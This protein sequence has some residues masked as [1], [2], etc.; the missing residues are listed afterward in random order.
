MG[1]LYQRFRIWNRARRYRWKDEPFECRFA[2]DCLQPGD[3]ALDIGAHKAAFT[4]WM[5]RRVGRR[6]R[7]YAFEPQPGLAAYLREFADTTPRRNVVVCEAALADTA[8]RS[9]LWIPATHL[10]WA[11]LQTHL[12]PALDGRLVEV[13]VETLDEWAAENDVPRPVSFIKCDV[14]L[15]ELAVFRGGEQL[16]SRDRPV[17]LFESHPLT[18]VQ[19]AENQTFAFLEQ[20]GYEGFFFHGRELLPVTSYSAACHRLT[21]DQVQNFV[22]VHPAVASLTRNRP[23]YSVQWAR[24][25]GSCPL[26]AEPAAA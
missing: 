7:V 26:I 17:L 18:R 22:F 9:S 23:P 10:G 24:A 14:E 16:L 11:R 5:S 8:G 2:C 6:G 13:R 1:S 15:H 21:N 19:T 25:G 20:L 12:E 3:V 4:Y